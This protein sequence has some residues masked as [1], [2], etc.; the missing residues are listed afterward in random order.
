MCGLPVIDPRRI[1]YTEILR[2][3]SEDGIRWNFGSLVNIV[4]SRYEAPSVELT[5]WVSAW[6]GWMI[7]RCVAWKGIILTLYGISQHSIITI[8]DL[9]YYN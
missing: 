7:L 9:W 8:P 3:W 5:D 1:A 4:S 2:V 6:H